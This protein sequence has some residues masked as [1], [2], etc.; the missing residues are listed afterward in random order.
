MTPNATVSIPNAAGE[1]R[2]SPLAT[3]LTCTRMAA[4]EQA[5]AT[6]VMTRPYLTPRAT[7]CTTTAA[8]IASAAN[9]RTLIHGSGPWNPARLS[10]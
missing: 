3:A 2:G 6:P 8:R 10:R 5:Y 1:G 7:E 9:D 4:T